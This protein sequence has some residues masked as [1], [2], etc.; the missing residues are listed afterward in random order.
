MKIKFVDFPKIYKKNREEYLKEIDRVLS[1][2]DLIL[3]DDVEKFEK[4]LADYCESN[5][6]V[7]VNSGTDALILSL[8][9][10][11]VGRGDEV[12]TTGY[13][14]WA[15][16][17]AILR[18]GAT[19]VLVDIK[20]DLII[21]ESLIEEKITDRTKAIIPV[22]IGGATYHAPTIRKIAEK[23]NISVIEDMAQGIGQVF[24]G[25][26]ACFSFYPAKVL[27]GFGD[28]GAIITNSKRLADHIK[29]L[30]NH[31]GKPYPKFVGYN[32]RLD[33]LQAAILNIKLRDL[34]KEI[35]RRTE[36]AKIYTRELS[37]IDG[38]ILPKETCLSNWQEYNI[39]TPHRDELYSLLEENG[40]E[41]IKGD[42]TFPID[43]PK[44]CR[45]ANKET[46]RLPICPELTNEQIEYVCKK[47]KEFFIK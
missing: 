28:G 22:C 47:V 37:V 21:D 27:G 3:R 1:N 38:L 30:R 9:A 16:V 34:G 10:L 41:T 39:Q 46:L 6:A 18:V 45:Q 13:T 32:S 24:S 43:S 40:I 17:E 4:S 44:R 31:G 8:D 2:G 19:P 33:N 26:T 7:G 29:L 36:I 20:D 12:I 42:Y 11:G 5:Y 23:Y 15:T 14:F 35:L 25:D